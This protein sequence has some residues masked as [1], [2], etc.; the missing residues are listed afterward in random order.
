MRQCCPKCGLKSFKSKKV[1]PTR[2]VIT[3]EGVVNK[4]YGPEEIVYTCT[5]GWR[6]YWNQLAKRPS[7]KSEKRARQLA[8][9]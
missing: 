7:R 6:G 1:Q 9:R 8:R 3:P 4:P 2:R 5:C